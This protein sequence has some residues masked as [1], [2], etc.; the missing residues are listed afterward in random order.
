[1]KTNF[2]YDAEADILYFTISEKNVDFSIDYDDTIIDV[3]GNKVV[4]VEIMNATEKFAK[5][6]NELDSTRK[7]LNSI[8]EAR[9]KVDYKLDSFIIKIGFTSQIPEQVSE[10]MIIQVPIRKELMVEI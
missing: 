8:K 5:S 2:S 4:G 7:M 3:S 1:M 6:D 9:M 10:G